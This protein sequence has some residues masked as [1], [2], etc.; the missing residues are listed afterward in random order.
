LLA[1]R[2]IACSAGRAE[3]PPLSEPSTGYVNSKAISTGD[4][5]MAKKARVKRLRRVKSLFDQYESVTRRRLV[6]A[7]FFCFAV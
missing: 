5:A 3:L 6:F 2:A 1:S 7:A 4:Q